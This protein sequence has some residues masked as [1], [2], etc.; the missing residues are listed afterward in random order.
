MDSRTKK[1][2]D[3]EAVNRRLRSQCLAMA[4]G[5]NLGGVFWDD[6]RFLVIRM[7]DPGVVDAVNIAAKVVGL[8]IKRKAKL[9]AARSLRK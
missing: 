2:R 4:N 8:N 5:I 1:I 6:E 9:V 7:E 3:L